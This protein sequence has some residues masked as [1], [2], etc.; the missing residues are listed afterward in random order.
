M[1]IIFVGTIY[2]QP[3]IWKFRIVILKE[4]DNNENND[5]SHHIVLNYGNLYEEEIG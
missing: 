5:I 4:E 2:G 1:C 3:K